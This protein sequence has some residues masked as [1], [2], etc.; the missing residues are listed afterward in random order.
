MAPR[1]KKNWKPWVSPSAFI[2]IVTTVKYL[3]KL[4]ELA[5]VAEE[6]I[7]QSRVQALLVELSNGN[8]TELRKLLFVDGDRSELNDDVEVLVN[9]RNIK[10]L[11]GMATSLGRED[12]VTL[13]Y[14]GV[15]GFPGG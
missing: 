15:R 12:R 9:G 8:R 6:N 7:N 2:D 4:R 10:F 14:H 13:L 11:D 1:R 3:G 5:S